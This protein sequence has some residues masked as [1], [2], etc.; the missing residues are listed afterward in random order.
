MGPPQE[1]GRYNMGATGDLCA[2]G[3]AAGDQA[4]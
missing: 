2:S 3:A 4:G 1:D